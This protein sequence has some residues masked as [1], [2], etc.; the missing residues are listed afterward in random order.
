MYRGQWPSLANGDLKLQSFEDLYMNTFIKK[1]FQ[2]QKNVE[3]WLSPLLTTYLY[4]MWK[5]RNEVRFRSNVNVAFTVNYMENWV[6]EFEE[7]DRQKAGRSVAGRGKGHWNPP[8]N[9]NLAVN[10]NV[11]WKLGTTAF[12]MVVCNSRGKLILVV[13]TRSTADSP[14]HAELKAIMWASSRMEE[15]RFE[16]LLMEM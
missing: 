16:S 10:V 1:C 11:A 5:L 12:A 4:A 2:P 14:K 7:M 15:K 6:D 3:D 13:A 8:T 9:G